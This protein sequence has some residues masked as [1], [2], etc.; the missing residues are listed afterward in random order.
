M[1]AMA[2]GL[3]PP[4]TL[5][6]AQVVVWCAQAGSVAGF[7]RRLVLSIADSRAHRTGLGQ[8]EG[9]WLTGC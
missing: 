1:Q 9:H 8:F 2:V 7:A 5:H 4:A 6:R 3:P